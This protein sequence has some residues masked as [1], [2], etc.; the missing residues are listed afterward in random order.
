MEVSITDITEVEKEIQIHA[1]ADELAPHFE[2]AY[3]RYQPKIEIKGFRKGKAPLDLIKK[4]YGESIEY[5]ALDTIASNVYRQVV[6]EKDIQ[7]IGQPV[8][9]DIDYKRGE[10]LTFKIKFEIKPNVELKEYKNIKV[11]KIIHPVTDKEIEEEILRLRRA[12]SILSSVESAT[13]DEHIVTVDIQELDQ[14]GNPLIGRK[15]TDVRMYLSDETVHPEIRTALK[16]TSVNARSQVKIDLEHDSR[17][18]TDYLEL[19]VKKID[20]VTLPEYNDEFVS[21]ITKQKI[22]TADEF[23][24]NV[25][26]DLEEYWHERSERKLTDAIVAE[27]VRRHDMTV[28]ETLVKGVLDSLIEELKN[29]YPNKKLLPDFDE[30]GFREEHQSYAI[31]QAKWYLLRERIIE[32]EGINVED[33]DLERSAEQDAPKVGIEKDRLLTFYKSSDTVKNRILSEKLMQFLKNHS[34]ITEKVTKEFID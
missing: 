3:K 4:I 6:T 24:H 11:E 18:L 13:D 32:T 5:D 21:K 22:K 15:S 25:R 34:V 8:L 29:R 19:T 14:T 27:I 1:S 20:K 2:E 16:N 7:P 12:N 31:F 26:K 23:Y 9:T 30:K 17:K 10:A 28:P 33:G